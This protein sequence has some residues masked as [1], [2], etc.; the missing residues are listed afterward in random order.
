MSNV[1]MHRI[2]MMRN[3][4]KIYL[5]LTMAKQM[6]RAAQ[7]AVIRRMRGKEPTQSPS[8]PGFTKT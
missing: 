7:K 4:M 6:S 2:R 1:S 5:P 8:L 3:T